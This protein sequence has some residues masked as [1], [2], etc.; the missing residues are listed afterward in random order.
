MRRHVLYRQ[1]LLHLKCC[2]TGHVVAFPNQLTS[3]ADKGADAAAKGGRRA[4]GAVAERLVHS[5]QQQALLR[6]HRERFG[7]H[8][9]KQLC[10][11]HL[12]M[13]HEHAKLHSRP[14]RW[15]GNGEG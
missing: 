3:N 5:V 2:H 13:W 15:G 11:K 4:A 7:A 9:T 1:G 8:D 6:V 12:H 10:I 14:H